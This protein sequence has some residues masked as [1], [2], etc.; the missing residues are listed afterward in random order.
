MR[1]LTFEQIH[2]ALLAG[3]LG[4]IGMKSET[5]ASFTGARGIKY[6]AHPGSALVKKAG[7]WVMAAELIDTTRLYARTLANIEPLWIEQVGTHLLKTLHSDP[8]WEKAR[9]Q[10]VAFE[11]GSLYGLPVYTQRRV[12]YAAINAKHARELFIRAALVEGECA[13]T[14]PSRH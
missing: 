4:N 3:L 9:G 11:R 7:R 12:D 13:R 8:H 14:R 10:T 1:L 2:R 6:F 5:E